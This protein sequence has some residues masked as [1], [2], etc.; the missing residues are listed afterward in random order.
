MNIKRPKEEFKT[1]AKISRCTEL[2]GLYLVNAQV[3]RKPEIGQFK[4]I[5]AEF[6]YSGSLFERKD[7]Q[8]QAKVDISVRGVNKDEDEPQPEVSIQGEY[9]VTYKIIYNSEICDADLEVFCSINALYNVWPYFRHLVSS[10]CNTMYIPQLLLPLLRIIQGKQA[11][12]RDMIE[13][14]PQV[15]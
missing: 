6:E 3:S 14:T 12:D 10:M 7:D 1:L 2:I 8:F 9:L 15:E 5:G 13:E 4:N 11:D